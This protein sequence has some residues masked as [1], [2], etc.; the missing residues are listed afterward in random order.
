MAKRKIMSKIL[1]NLS[2]QTEDICPTNKEYNGLLIELS[3]TTN[4]ILNRE[5]I[6]EQTTYNKQQIHEMGKNIFIV[7]NKK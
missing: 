5:L 7:L 3:Y 1:L 2:L 4:I 6:I